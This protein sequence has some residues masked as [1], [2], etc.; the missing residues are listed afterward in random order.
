MISG[1][2]PA[3]AI[4]LGNRDVMLR[5]LSAIAFGAAEP[6]LAG[7]MLEYVNEQGEVK[8]E[9]VNTLV[10]AVRAQT[11]Y[12]LQLARQAWGDAILLECG[13]TEAALQTHLE[14]L[15]ARITDVALRTARQVQELRSAL[16]RFSATLQGRQPGVRAADLVARLLGIPSSQR[17]NRSEANDASAGYP[18][19]RFAEF[20]IL[21]GYEFPSEPA[22]LRLLGDVN[23]DSP[24]SAARRFGIYQF[25]PDAPVYARARRWK[26]IGLDVSSPWNPRSDAP[27][28]YRLC[29]R[30]EL[31]YSTDHAKCP[32]CHLAEPGRAHPAFEFGGFLAQ[33][34]EAPVLD[35]EDRIAARNL[36]AFYP[37]WNGE[38]F[39]RWS[40]GP[41]W[42]LQL[43]RNEEVRWLNEGL[44]PTDAERDRGSLLHENAR[45]F[46]LCNLCGR[47]LVIPPPDDVGTR[48]RART[49][50]ARDPLATLPTACAPAS[51]RSPPGLSRVLRRKCCDWLH[52][53]P[54][55][56]IRLPWKNGHTL[57]AQHYALASAITCCWTGTKLILNPKARGRSRRTQVHFSVCL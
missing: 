23:E 18:P 46:S 34:N 54:K 27:W 37:Q 1:E 29:R 50:N 55:V 32:R 43:S 5:H 7:R 36:V 38:V 6:G 48:R 9:A 49:G 15:P 17:D 51:H 11:G 10:A 14:S 39:E 33:R 57:S 13:L 20:G 45:G 52:S 47:Q 40:V 28:N 53:F 31:R 44:E 8:T 21:P 19:R 42:Q 35:E 2:I 26:V 3:P 30:C 25:M 56:S 22:S 12:A 24:I 16:E 41:G 4:S